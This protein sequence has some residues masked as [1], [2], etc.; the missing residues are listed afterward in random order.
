[1]RTDKYRLNIFGLP[2]IESLDDFAKV[3]NLSKQLLYKLS[4][5]PTLNYLVYPKAKSNGKVRQICQPSK[6]L[7]AVQGWILRNILN[8]LESHPAC[9]GFEIGKSILDNA[10]PHV[11]SVIVMS[12]D[13][14]NFFPRVPANR[15]WMLFNTL[16]YNPFICTILT[17]LCTYEGGLPQGSPTS[18]KLANLVTYRLDSRLAGYTGGKGI[19]YTRYADDMTFSASSYAILTSAINT[20][21]QIIKAEGFTLNENK[22]RIAGP[23]RRHSVTGLVLGPE[24]AG[25]GRQ[26]IRELRVRIHRLCNV[27]KSKA[28]KTELASLN[29]WFAF[30]N[31]VDKSRTKIL[32]EY[33]LKLK[34]KYPGSAIDLLRFQ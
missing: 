8:K 13:L 19:V 14:E 33:I 6:E 24:S 12:F 20:I 25:V 21:R 27:E 23:S 10:L 3:T 30:I 31:G 34:D 32:Q 16:G 4:K 7:K 11:G 5:Y 29:G 28:P 17:N 9:K 22:T 15:V 26:C 1:M 2:S 18:P